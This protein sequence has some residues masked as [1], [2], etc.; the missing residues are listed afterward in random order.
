MRTRILG[1][2]FRD[3]YIPCFVSVCDVQAFLALSPC[4]M[5]RHSLLCLLIRAY[6][7]LALSPCP[8]IT[9]AVGQMVVNR[10][11]DRVASN[12]KLLC[13]GLYIPLL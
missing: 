3:V 11:F 2:R 10:F 7:F 13:S 9:A 12:I 6:I 1:Q 8:E 5:Y 4:A